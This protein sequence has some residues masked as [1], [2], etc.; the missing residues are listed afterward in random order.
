MLRRGDGE[1]AITIQACFADGRSPPRGALPPALIA[2][3][4]G[5]PL[6][7]VVQR[8]LER[9]FGTNFADVRVH[10]GAAASRLGAHAFTAGSDI[11]FAHGR[12]QPHT[13]GG[14]ALLGRQ[15]AYVVQQRQ[16][17][18][19]STASPGRGGIAVVCDPALEAEAERMSVLAG[20]GPAA[21][22]P[23]PR[24]DPTGAPLPRRA[25]EAGR[26]PTLAVPRTVQRAAA[27][28]AASAAKPSAKDRD[29]DDRG[30]DKKDLDRGKDDKQLDPPDLAAL[31]RLLPR[32]KER[33]R[34]PQML[35]DLC[36]RAVRAPGLRVL[37]STV[38]KDGFGDL[39]NCL[40]TCK[41]LVDHRIAA[42]AQSNHRA[43]VTM[44]R[45]FPGVTTGDPWPDGDPMRIDLAVANGRG[46]E[47]RAG[48][49]EYGYL[50]EKQAR[51]PYTRG[52][53]FA[54]HEVGVMVEPELW[55]QQEFAPEELATSSLAR[56][57]EACDHNCIGIPRF[58]FGY[59]AGISKRDG[60]CINVMLDRVLFD[61]DILEAVVVLAGHDADNLTKY[62]GNQDRMRALGAY[63]LAQRPSNLAREGCYVHRFRSRTKTV[64]VV[65]VS[66]TVPY[67][68]MQRMWSWADRSFVVCEG[69]Q[70]FSEALSTGAPI[71][72]QQWQTGR[73]LN[74]ERFFRDFVKRCGELDHGVGE[75]LVA[76]EAYMRRGNPVTGTQQ[77][78]L[79]INS[80]CDPQFLAR[81]RRT[82]AAVIA[83]YDVT[84]WL[85]CFA[86][87]L[88]VR[89]LAANDDVS[90]HPIGAKLREI[91]ELEDGGADPRKIEAKVAGVVAELED[92]ARNPRQ[93]R[94]IVD[95][96]KRAHAR[97]LL[98]PLD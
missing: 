34:S 90:F 51:E 93:F 73:G 62:L 69:D 14:L 29:D 16:G 48:I 42:S 58:F 35:I 28:A 86:K 54:P 5:Q 70:S 23:T 84:P 26:A 60:G 65:L 6:P 15:L 85:P 21:R 50:D 78:G 52:E 82:I 94:L 41:I 32:R 17:R 3:S 24:T 2:G 38:N 25:S 4:R 91:V 81:Y 40:K 10:V 27:A 30:K 33:K 19:A 96:M 53:G 39:L 83:N 66:M 76:A 87:R 9:V 71:G 92:I 20:G 22:P 47:E 98:V 68:D 56:V 97:N 80:C 12:Y 72:Y 11:Y 37:V 46:T 45:S 7:V 31:L 67:A 88:W 95:H 89:Q 79:I 49:E 63:E 64:F 18:V 55:V 36:Y 75:F 57:L 1:R 43:L 74:K 13:A 59:G 8:K 44:A 77:L 61:D